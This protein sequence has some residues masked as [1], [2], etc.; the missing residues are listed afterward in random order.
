[1]GKSKWGVVVGVALCINLFCFGVAAAYADTVIKANPKSGSDAL[2]TI[3]KKLDVAKKKATSKN[4][5]IVKVKPGSYKLG[6]T[7]KLYSNTTL[8]LTGVTLKASKKTSNMIKVGDAPTDNKR[9]YAY[10][11]IKLLGG[12]LNRAGHSSTAVVVGHAKNVTL[13]GVTIHNSRNAHLVEAAG[14]VGFTADGCTFYD[15]IQTQ[16]AK[17]GTPEAIQIDILVKRHLKSYRSEAL[18]TKN[19]VV[20]NCTFR[21]VPRGVGSHTAILNSPMTN[22]KIL[23]NRFTNCASAGIQVLNFES[24]TIEGNVIDGAPRGIIV[25][26]VNTKGVFLAKSLSKEGGIKS[27]ISNKYKK[28]KSNQ[29]IVIRNNTIKLAGKE[30]YSGSENEGIFIEGFDFKKTLKKNSQTDA[31]PK[32]NYYMSGVTITGNTITTIGHGIRLSNARN[33]VISNNAITFAGTNGSSKDYYGIQLTNA[34][35]GN[36]ITDNR[37]TNPRTNGIFV[38]GKSSASKIEGNTITNAGK[39]GIGLQESS[40]SYIRN[41]TVDGAGVCG[42]SV[43]K[44]STANA[45]TENTLISTGDFGIL[46]KNKSKVKSQSGNSITGVRRPIFIQ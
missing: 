18:P 17:V 4:K 5:Y 42:V 45:I 43:I 20:K 6:G 24:C 13:K 22:I 36:A 31:I 1:M 29:R 7:L 46:C 2:K 12:D 33:T 28:P 14:I 15:Q 41:N 23:N 30:I 35:V 16:K 26:R 27:K 37:I 39:Y 11:N 25:H 9:G 3:Q 21:N 34:S 10:K 44:S 38:L 19:V 8:D 40:V 32:G